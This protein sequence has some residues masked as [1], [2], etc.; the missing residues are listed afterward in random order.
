MLD[1]LDLLDMGVRGFAPKTA[2]GAVIEAV[3]RLVVAGGRYLPP[4]FADIAASLADGPTEQH[5]AILKLVKLSLYNNK[6]AQ[7]LLRVPLIVNTHITQIRL[8]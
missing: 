1:L 2:C 7:A 8:Y 3:R 5:L 4:R 6:I